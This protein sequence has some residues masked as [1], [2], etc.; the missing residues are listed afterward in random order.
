M[1]TC[2]TCRSWADPLGR[3]RACGAAGCDDCLTARG[4]HCA[5]CFERL[6]MVVALDQRRILQVR[7]RETQIASLTADLSALAAEVEAMRA[8]ME[9]AGV[10]L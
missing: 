4:E 8:A 6:E 1:P 9:E 2:T 7:R 5:A 3:C 10:L